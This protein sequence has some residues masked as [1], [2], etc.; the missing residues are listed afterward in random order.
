MPV[1]LRKRK[2]LS[3]A[4][5]TISFGIFDSWTV[6]FRRDMVS[7]PRYAT[8]SLAAALALTVI[9]MSRPSK[10]KNRREPQSFANRRA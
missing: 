2:G 1:R 9:S 4:L 7:T 3:H 8:R 5:D 10:S 6:S